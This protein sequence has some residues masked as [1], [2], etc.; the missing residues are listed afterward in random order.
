MKEK[1]EK[2][3]RELG[4]LESEVKT[5]LAAL[6]RGPSSVSDLAAYTELTRQSIYNA[7]GQLIARGLMTTSDTRSSE[8]KTIFMAESPKKLL[9]CAEQ[10]RREF[11]ILVDELESYIPEIEMQAGGDRPTVRVLEGYDG[12]REAMVE[13][14]ASGPEGGFE[15]VD[16]TSLRN[17]LLPEHI[18]SLHQLVKKQTERRL[19]GLYTEDA[20]PRLSQTVERLGILPAE[21]AGF[22]SILSVFRDKV[23]MV[24]LRG[25]VY[26]VI[27]EDENFVKAFKILFEHTYD[28][29][30]ENETVKAKLGT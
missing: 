29:L 8:G 6:S 20:S 2:I 16:F 4:L 10:K 30:T 12:L 5:Y 1:L 7:T 19:T 22:G 25:K 28:H 3:L 24:S 15:M 18:E 9:A 23:V 13:I 17:I 26:T 27:I 21:D 11:D 14:I